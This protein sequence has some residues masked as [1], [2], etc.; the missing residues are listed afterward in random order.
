MAWYESILKAAGKAAAGQLLDQIGG[1]NANRLKKLL[2][3]KDTEVK[4]TL[5]RLEE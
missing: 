2:L 5:N 4:E 1:P 3:G